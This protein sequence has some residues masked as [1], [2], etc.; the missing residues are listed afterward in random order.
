M[1]VARIVTFDG[2]SSERME[3]MRSEMSAQERPDNV[4]ATEIMVLHDPE[5]EKSV[6]LLFFDNEDDYATGDAAL[7]AMPASDTP[8]SRSSVGKYNVEMR[9]TAV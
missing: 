5:A 8:G 7:N 9:M 2:V 4:P 3:Q 1:A 6:V